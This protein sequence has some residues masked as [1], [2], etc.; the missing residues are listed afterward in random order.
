MNDDKNL[1]VTPILIA[2]NILAFVFS[3]FTVQGAQFYANGALVPYDVVEG[4]MTYQLVT[5][6]FLHGS[7]TH[8]L[9]NMVSLYYLGR[10]CELLYGKVR[11]LVIY[12][13]SGLAGG[14]AYIAVAYLIGD[15]P[16][17]GGNVMQPCVG[18]SGAIFGLLGAQGFILLKESVKPVLLAYRPSRQMVTQWLAVLAVN[19]GY[20]FLSAGIAWQAHIGGLV[21]GLVLGA[22]LYFTVGGVR[23]ERSFGNAY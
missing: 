18:A 14:I 23:K 11:M 12:L 8:I 22:I 2:L 9:C 15:V 1:M 21:A 3:M 20:G 16:I 17:I 13:L 5:S 10:D 19:V 6:M 4:G 7:I